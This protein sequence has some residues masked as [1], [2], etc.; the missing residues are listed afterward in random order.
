MP[1]CEILTIFL[2]KAKDLRFYIFLFWSQCIYIYVFSSVAGGYWRCKEA[3]LSWKHKSQSWPKHNWCKTKCVSFG[4]S[5]NGVPKADALFQNSRRV[6]YESP[7]EI[8]TIYLISPEVR[9]QNSLWKK[10]DWLWKSEP[11]GDAHATSKWDACCP[12][13]T[14]VSS[15]GARVRLYW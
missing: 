11:K 12:K 7:E 6:L 9:A 3:I 14:C 13:E 1:A 8:R 4:S 15:R 10:R 2:A 5:K